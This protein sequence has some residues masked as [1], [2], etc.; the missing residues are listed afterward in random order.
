[1]PGACVCGPSASSAHERPA[2]TLQG[3]QRTGAEAWAQKRKPGLSAVA[4]GRPGFPFAWPPASAKNA[5]KGCQ[6]QMGMS[7]A[8]PAEE[9][10]PGPLHRRRRGHRPAAGWSLEM[11]GPALLSPANSAAASQDSESR[12]VLCPFTPSSR[13]SLHQDCH[14]RKFGQIG[15]APCLC[16]CSGE[17]PDCSRVLPDLLKGG[18]WTG[19]ALREPTSVYAPNLAKAF[20]HLDNEHGFPGPHSVARRIPLHQTALS[21]ESPAQAAAVKKA[22]DGPIRSKDQRE[23]EDRDKSNKAC[24]QNN[25]SQEDTQPHAPGLLI[26][27]PFHWRTFVMRYAYRRHSQLSANNHLKTSVILKSNCEVK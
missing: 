14:V 10:R 16:G 9:D 23:Q 3:V 27:G 15:L 17:P 18:Q 6:R 1:M 24:W 8:R 19:L 2:L 25:G 26:V 11:N 20:Q 4:A 21:V 13:P 12:Q 5:P 7:A 22:A